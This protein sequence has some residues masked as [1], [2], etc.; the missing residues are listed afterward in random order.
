M[1]ARYQVRGPFVSGYARWTVVDTSKKGEPAIDV[2]RRKA[3]AIASAR[4]ANEVDGGHSDEDL[5]LRSQDAR[6]R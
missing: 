1:S 5:L 3:D 6:N 4:E 2:A